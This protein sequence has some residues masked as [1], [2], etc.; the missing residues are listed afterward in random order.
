NFSSDWPVSIFDNADCF[1]EEFFFI[2]EIGAVVFGA[3]GIF[4]YSPISMRTFVALGANLKLSA[5]MR[6]YHRTMT[7]ALV[8]QV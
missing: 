8:I 3:F 7:K 4:I 2:E 5:K 1:A 6:Y